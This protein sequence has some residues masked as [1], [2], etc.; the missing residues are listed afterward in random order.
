M[1]KP[2]LALLAIVAL[3]AACAPK[4][5][6]TSPDYDGARRHSERSH[7]QSLDKQNAD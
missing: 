7:T 6:E 4:R 5:M 3:A 2:M 1:R